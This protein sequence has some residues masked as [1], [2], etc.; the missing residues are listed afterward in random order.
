[1]RIKL[2]FVLFCLSLFTLA[3]CSNTKPP[4][5]LDN[6][7]DNT[8][9][10]CESYDAADWQK[11]MKEYERLLGEYYSSEKRYSEAEKQMAARAMGR[12]HALLIKYGIKQSTEYLKELGSIIPSYLEGLKEEIEQNSEEITGTFEGLFDEKEIEKAAEGL[13]KALNDLFGNNEKDTS[14]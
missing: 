14:K 6:F 8:E 7:V 5:K 11:S 13:E 2:N 1:M 10:K 4:Q 9:L 3:E 12:Y